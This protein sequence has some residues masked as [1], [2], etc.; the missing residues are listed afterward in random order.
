MLFRYANGGK[1]VKRDVLALIYIISY[2]RILTHYSRVAR[3]GHQ[4]LTPLFSL[5]NKQ[6]YNIETSCSDRTKKRGEGRAEEEE[7]GK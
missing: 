3:G 6:K 7:T 5:L 2:N 1:E 4:C